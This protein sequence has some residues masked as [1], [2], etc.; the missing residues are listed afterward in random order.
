MIDQYDKFW[1][2]FKS[3]SRDLAQKTVNAHTMFDQLFSV[4]ESE[5]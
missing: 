3:W 5:R 2:Q 4:E 1:Q